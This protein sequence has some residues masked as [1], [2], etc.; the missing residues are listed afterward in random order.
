VKV[1]PP[2]VAGLCQGERQPLAFPIYRT[3]SAKAANRQR[4]AMLIY[5][6][7]SAKA[8]N[9]NRWRSD[10]PD[11]QRQPVKVCLIYPTA[12]ASAK[13]AMVETAGVPIYPTA[14]ASAKA[15]MVETAGVPIYP[16]GLRQPVKVCLIYPTG[17]RQ[18][19]KVCLIY[20]TASASAKAA[21]VETAGVDLPDWTAPACQGEGAQRAIPTA[22]ASAKA[23]M[24]ETAGVP[25]LPDC[26]RQPVKVCLIYSTGPRQRR[27]PLAFLIYSTAS[28]SR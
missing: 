6:T 11:C 7:A 3:A 20:P 9:G 8:A 17:L 25:D 12:S 19:V 14:S 24:V 26:Q 1:Y 27:Q 28:A 5:R 16:T 21:M 23:A 18:P 2:L 22:S 15:A 13:A 4:L 10:L